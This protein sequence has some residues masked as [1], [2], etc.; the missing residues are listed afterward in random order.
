[1][2]L[3]LVLWLPVGAFL[4]AMLVLW[5]GAAMLR[6]LRA[7]IHGMHLMPGGAIEVVDGRRCLRGRL[8]DG[9]FVAP[10]LTIVRWRPERAF[11]DRTVLVLP[12]MLDE[13]AFRALRVALKWT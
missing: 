10:W 3:A 12:G 8:V 2:T 11:F 5:I 4:R 7:G 1:M 9:S 13:D 6:S